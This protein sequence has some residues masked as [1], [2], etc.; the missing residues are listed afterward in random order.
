[1]GFFGS[2]GLAAPTPRGTATLGPLLRVQT[3]GGTPV[4][5]PFE[6]E[7]EITHTSAGTWVGYNDDTGCPLIA[8]QLRLTGVQ[9]IPTDGGP[10]RYVE[11]PPAWQT[12]GYYS[13]DPD[14]APDPSG[15]GGVLLATLI[16]NEKGLVVG[17]VRIP[18]AGR[19][20][21]LPSPS[22]GTSD[23]KEYLATDS[24]GASPFRGRTY[25]AWDDFGSG[26]ITVRAFEGSGG[27]SRSCLPTSRVSPTSQSLRTV[28]SPW[29][30]PPMPASR[31]ASPA[32]AGPPSATLS[33]L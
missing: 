18:P 17:V 25:L 12:A 24:G 33:R 20:T 29:R 3:P 7:P 11:L 16:S 23:D 32:M 10:R 21:L 27:S 31:C 19:A 6:S 26:K 28:T 30:T 14:L 8:P 15:N 2:A 9:L 1:V 13:G 5:C 22:L 4:S